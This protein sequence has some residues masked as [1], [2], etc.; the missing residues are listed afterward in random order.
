M[1]LLCVVICLRLL[2]VGGGDGATKIGD[3]VAAIPTC[4]GRETILEGSRAWRSSSDHAIP[5]FIATN[6]SVDTADTQWTHKEFYQSYADER[7]Q[8][9]DD[10]HEH[11]KRPGDMR[12]AMS[13]FLAHAR[14]VKERIEY[15]WLLYGR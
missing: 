15:K 7:Q 1:L 4:E 11:G 14:F 13:P 12:S 3:L 8:A 6:S 2:V 9:Y 10:G 5:T